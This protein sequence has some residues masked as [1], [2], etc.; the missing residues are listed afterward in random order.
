M[1]AS[2][3]YPQYD[4]DQARTGPT[5]QPRIYGNTLDAYHDGSGATSQAT[6]TPVTAVA[7]QGRVSNLARRVHGWSWQAVCSNAPSLGMRIRVN[8]YRSSRLGWAPVR[9]T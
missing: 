4:L 1:A 5:T 8:S 2:S 7:A 3:S 6:L 9:Y